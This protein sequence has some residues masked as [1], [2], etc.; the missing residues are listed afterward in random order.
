MDV[1]FIKQIARS[2]PEIIHVIIGDGARF[3]RKEGQDN[4]ESLPGNVRILTLP[5]Y[6]PELNPI[7]KLWDVVKDA[8]CTVN[9]KDLAALEERMTELLKEWWERPEG[10][11][12][13]FT[14]SYLRSELNV[15]PKIFKSYL[16]C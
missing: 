6:S 2:A 1:A 8:V 5:P 10:F 11:S 12:S 14:N 3:H 7:E 15:T 16:Y 9:W 13:L 4:E